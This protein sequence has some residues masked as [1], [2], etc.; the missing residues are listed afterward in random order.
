MEKGKSIVLSQRERITDRS[1]FRILL[2]DINAESCQEIESL[3]CKCSYQVAAVWSP[4]E[5]FDTLNSQ[6]PRADIILASVDLLMENEAQMK[7]RLAVNCCSSFSI[8]EAYFKLRILL[9][10]S[11]PCFIFL[12]LFVQE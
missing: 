5:V 12:G 3:L 8:S 2:C 1:K 4:I 6:G 10:S 7:A 11:F 9:F